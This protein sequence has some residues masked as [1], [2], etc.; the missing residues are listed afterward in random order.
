MGGRGNAITIRSVSQEL[1]K[2]VFSLTERSNQ[3]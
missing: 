2:K 3:G 1:G